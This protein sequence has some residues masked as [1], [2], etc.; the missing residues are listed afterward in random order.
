MELERGG[1]RGQELLGGEHAVR[2]G[3]GV[4]G[5]QYVAHVG[6]ERLPT[7]GAG[8]GEEEADSDEDDKHRGSFGWHP[9]K[10]FLG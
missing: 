3:H 8:C 1:H 4:H 2:R 5:V 10:T 9:E 7:A 6:A